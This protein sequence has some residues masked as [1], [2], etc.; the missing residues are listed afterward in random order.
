MGFDDR[1]TR[2]DQAVRRQRCWRRGPSTPDGRRRANALPVGRPDRNNRLGD[3]ADR[4]RR[5]AASS[6]GRLTTSIR[7]GLLAVLVVALSACTAGG[8]GP[9]TLT[10]GTPTGTARPTPEAETIGAGGGTYY[11]LVDRA[12]PRHA[13]LTIDVVQFFTGAPAT[14]ACAQDG[15][16]D[17]HGLLCHAYY[18]R[19]RSLRLSTLSVRPDAVTTRCGGRS[20]TFRN[21]PPA[22]HQLVRLRVA[23]RVVTRLDEICLP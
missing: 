14:R 4:R 16:P 8:S 12:D 11:G 17:Q 13:T 21:A 1:G 6:K 18:V 15:V 7:T 22:R 5:D 2:P 20:S 9:S 3:R 10:P 23:R 19:D